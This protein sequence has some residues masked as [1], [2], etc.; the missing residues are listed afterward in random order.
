M[1]GGGGGTG[2]RFC[3]V[4][5]LFQVDSGLLCVATLGKS[6]SFIFSA[7]IINMLGRSLQY[8][9]DLLDVCTFI[10]LLMVL[11]FQGCLFMPACVVCVCVHVCVCVRAVRG[12]NP[13]K[14]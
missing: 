9:V 3:N 7:L 13:V 11:L 8:V 10:P 12:E 1:G 14:V 6:K 2:K 5:S 4:C